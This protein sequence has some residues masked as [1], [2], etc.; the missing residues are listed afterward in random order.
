MTSHHWNLQAAIYAALTGANVSGGRVYDDVPESPT[1]PYVQIG[2]DQAIPDDVSPGDLGVV[3]TISLHTWSRHRGQKEI[4][5]I[6]SEITDTLHGVSLNVTGRASALVWVRI[7]RIIL[8]PD[9][10]TRHG[11]TDIEIIHRS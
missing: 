7:T 10:L 8:D 9:G 3:E 4:K 11:I 1:F 5:D 6:V 2:E